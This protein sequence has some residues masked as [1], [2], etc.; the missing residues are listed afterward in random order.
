MPRQNPEVKAIIEKEAKLG[1]QLEK[2]IEVLQKQVYEKFVV[3]LIFN[4]NSNG[5]MD[6]NIVGLAIAE[7]KMVKDALKFQL[8]FDLR[9]SLAWTEQ[10]KNAQREEVKLPLV[11]EKP[12]ATKQE[13]EEAHPLM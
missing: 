11:N 10:Q 1:A 4:S 12:E 5:T 9:E 8:P 7:M 13:G 2:L 6:D 3:L